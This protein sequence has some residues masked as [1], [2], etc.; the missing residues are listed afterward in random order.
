VLEWIEKAGRM[1]LHDNFR[2]IFVSIKPD[3]NGPVSCFADFSVYTARP[4][5]VGSLGHMGNRYYLNFVIMYLPSPGKL[6]TTWPSLLKCSSKHW[7][8][9]Y[10]FR[11]LREWAEEEW[12]I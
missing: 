5:V 11:T 7:I 3:A 9:G 12:T 2:T 8:V 1:W 10:L 6:G 4:E